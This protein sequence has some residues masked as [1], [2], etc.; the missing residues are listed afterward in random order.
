MRQFPPLGGSELSGTGATLGTVEE[1]AEEELE[2]AATAP[3]GL[4]EQFMAKRLLLG[5]CSTGPRFRAHRAADLVC[6]AESAEAAVQTEPP[7]PSAPLAA[8]REALR[9]PPEPLIG[10]AQP[11]LPVVVSVEGPAAAGN[12]RAAAR[13]ARAAE[14]ALAPFLTPG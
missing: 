4:S 11:A 12:D 13:A 14:R 6:V 8:V 1:D 10:R 3:A 5:T 2:Q 9:L 7:E